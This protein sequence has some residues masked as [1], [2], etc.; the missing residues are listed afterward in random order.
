L[1]KISFFEPD[2]AFWMA[3]IALLM[4]FRMSVCGGD[5]AA[6]DL[7]MIGVIPTPSR[8]PARSSGKPF[9]QMFAE[10]VFNAL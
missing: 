4:A 3:E 5:E 6:V 9:F 7:V 1:D 2:I 8:T 10:I